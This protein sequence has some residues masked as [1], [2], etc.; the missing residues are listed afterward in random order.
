MANDDQSGANGPAAGS[1]ARDIQP[2]FRPG[3]ITCMAR[4]HV[5]L[6]DPPGCA[7]R[8]VPPISLITQTPVGS[9]PR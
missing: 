5:L 8:P 4:R 6:N 1:Y 7:I 2:K 3:D 9:T